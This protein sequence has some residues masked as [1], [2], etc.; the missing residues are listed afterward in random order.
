MRDMGLRRLQSIVL[1]SN[2]STGTSDTA[3][4]ER[5]TIMKTLRS[6]TAGAAVGAGVAVE[7]FNRGESEVGNLELDEKLMK[8]QD[9]MGDSGVL[10]YSSKY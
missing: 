1:G 9:L 7:D 10:K 2:A 4:E 5:K 8:L 6:S 3:T